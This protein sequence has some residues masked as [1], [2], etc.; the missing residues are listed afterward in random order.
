MTA[1]ATWIGLTTIFIAVL[2]GT[3]GLVA[4]FIHL[5][6]KGRL[7]GTTWRLGLVLVIIVTV[8]KACFGNQS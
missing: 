2:F 5:Y 8:L 6:N 4:L 1:V 7:D 3:V